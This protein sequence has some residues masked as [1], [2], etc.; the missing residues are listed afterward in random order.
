M[1]CDTTSDTIELMGVNARALRFTDQGLAAYKY[2]RTAVEVAL[3][4]HSIP[5]FLLQ[6]VAIHEM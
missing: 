4:N 3:A 5:P 2:G 6:L 1:P